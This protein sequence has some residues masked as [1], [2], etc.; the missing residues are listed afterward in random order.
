MPNK[1]SPFGA[2]AKQPSLMIFPIMFLGGALGASL[3]YAIEISLQGSIQPELIAT[4]LVNL[5]GA[6]L[7][8][9]VNC[10]PW[11]RSLNRKVF[12]GHG[13]LGGFTTMSGL[14]A[15]SA[16]AEMG[17]GA[18]WYWYWLFVLAQLGLG[19][20]S[21]ALGIEIAKRVSK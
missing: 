3:R 6:G 21:Y 15:I 16:S 7:L 2:A 20:V 17:L 13:L 4:S 9:F 8:G 1:A 11:F 14:A 18:G 10:Y 19:L 12:F 5:L